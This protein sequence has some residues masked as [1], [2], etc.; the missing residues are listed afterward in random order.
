M[1]DRTCSVPGCTRPY[2]ARGWCMMHYKRAR[3]GTPL[4]A[5][6]LGHLKAAGC[7]ATGCDRPHWS[8]GY[9]TMHNQRTDPNVGQVRRYG[10]LVDGCDL[11]HF[12][13]GY[14]RAHYSRH[15]R[16]TLTATCAE[17]GAAFVRP[18]GKHGSTNYCSTACAGVGPAGWA[19]K[20]RD[21]LAL[22]N[23]GMTDQDRADAAAY[24]VLIAAD[25]CAYCGAPCAAIDHIVPVVRGGSDRWDNLA[26]ICK[27]CN[28][29]KRDRSVLTLL[30]ALAA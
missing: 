27:S 20:R 15:L 22:N 8:N 6:V 19:Q 25:P 9:C 10:C 5:P 30:M 18:L 12:G 13:A 28:S 26:A 3:K 11:V 4:D 2:G 14:C 1:P 21:R 23:A 7:T 16:G 17:C 24:R 29:R